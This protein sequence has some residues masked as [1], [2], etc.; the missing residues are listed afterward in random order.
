MRFRLALLSSAL[1]IA[2]VP[3][4]AAWHEAKSKH[5]VVY[6]DEN[7]NELQQYAEKLE[8][9]DQA[10]RFIRRMGDPE[11][12]D[13]GRVTLFVLP[14]AE[15]VGQLLGS[16]AVRGFY[17]SRADGSYAFVPHRSG[18]TMTMGS[19][20]GTGIERDTLNP[21]QVF[22]HEYAHHLQLQDW[23]GVMP[24]WVAEGFAE[25]FA[26]AEIDKNGNVTIGKF[27]SYRSWDVFLGNGLSADELVSADYDNLNFYE[28]AAL[29]GRSWLLTHYLNVSGKRKGQ[30]SAYLDG[31]E[32][33]MKPRDSAKAAFGDL[34]ALQRELDDYIKP[35]SLVA[36]TVDAHFIPVG[37]VAVRQ[38]SPAEAATMPVRIRSKAGVNDKTA[39]RV[40]AQARG[41]AAAYPNDPAAQSALAEA[42]FDAKDYGASEAAADRALAADPN[43]LSALVYKG[44]AELEL[45]RLKPAQANWDAIRG[46]FTRANKIDTEYAL[47]LALFYES[48][49]VAGRTPSDNALDA[50]L[51]AVDLAPRDGDLRMNAVR[52]LVVANRLKDA[53]EL[54]AP[55]A[56]QP[57]LDKDIRELVG[58]IMTAITAGDG[59]SAVSLIDSAAQLEKKKKKG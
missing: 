14:D 43:N 35:R 37:R 24:V 19:S 7:P 36:F 2:A 9:F 53:K 33:G 21:Q 48:F 46:W 3:A 13:S 26:T 20:D 50:L 30:L 10:V 42:E 18:V 58:K 1:L 57:H 40:A 47:P 59:K 44:H 27:P 22:F 32:K 8:R 55:M 51:Y 29:Y 17:V 34:K 23:N 56:Y 25:F 38:L 12:T 15:S 5:F 6:A 52:A 11:L 54:F 39:L 4:H 41:V 45:A 49:A 31:I 28:I 16:F